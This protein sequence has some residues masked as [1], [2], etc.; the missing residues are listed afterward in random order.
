MY[1]QPTD[2]HNAIKS[3]ARAW[4]IHEKKA[5]ALIGLGQT[6]YFLLRLIVHD[7][8]RFIDTPTEARV[9]NI[10]KTPG[11]LKAATSTGAYVYPLTSF[12]A[13][14]E[15][16]KWNALYLIITCSKDLAT[17]LVDGWLLQYSENET[18]KD[19]TVLEN[20]AGY[21]EPIWDSL[22]NR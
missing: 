18:L 1:R 5:L 13:H 11:F 9:F 12:P 4:I 10:K 17:P 16:P 8:T 21:V 6:G 14:K 15:D 22:Y 20:P 19:Y 3:H 7:K 2:L